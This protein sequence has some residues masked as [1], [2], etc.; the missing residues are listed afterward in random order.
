MLE[1][2]F[3]LI[4]SHPRTHAKG[5]SC[6]LLTSNCP[7]NP[8]FYLQGLCFVIVGSIASLSAMMIRRLRERCSRANGGI[9]RSR[10]REGGGLTNIEGPIKI[11]FEYKIRS[12][13]SI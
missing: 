12:I 13:V 6:T 5:S 3:K 1:S 11:I 9:A 2:S 4:R 8:L 10:L 7:Y